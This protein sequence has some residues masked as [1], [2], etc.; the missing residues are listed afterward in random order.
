[1]PTKFVLQD[2][3]HVL[4]T[5]WRYPHRIEEVRIGWNL[6][7]RQHREPRKHRKPVELLQDEP[8]GSVIEG[9]VRGERANFTG[10]ALGCV[11]AKVCI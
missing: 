6:S 7:E 10:L 8:E 3:V 1:M 9:S 2:F 11:E 4:H 5:K